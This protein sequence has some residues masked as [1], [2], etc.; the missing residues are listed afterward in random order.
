MSPMMLC[1][2]VDGKVRLFFMCLYELTDCWLFNL[3]GRLVVS[4]AACRALCYDNVTD[5]ASV[6]FG[7]RYYE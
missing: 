7:R 4:L 2:A 3:T 5:L 1:P 6:A